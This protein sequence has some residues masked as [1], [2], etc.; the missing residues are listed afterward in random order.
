[1]KAAVETDEA[2]PSRVPARQLDGGFDRLG[3][4]VGHEAQGVFFEGRNL[5]QLFAELHPLFVIE[6][7]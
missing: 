4:R 2:R 6:V 3:A 1:V 7:G 5:I